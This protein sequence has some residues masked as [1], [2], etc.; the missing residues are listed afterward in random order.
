MII[1]RLIGG[2]GNQMFQY[3]LGRQL[4]VKNN[5]T[6]KLD[7]QA[8]KDYKLRNYDLDCF[9]ILENIAT[10]D[11]L[12][13]VIPPSDR[14]INKIGKHMN[15]RLK[16]IQ[17]I[18]YIKEQAF[19]FQQE[20]L[21]LKDNVYLDG[22]WQSEK[23]FFD[24]KNIILKDFT[25]KNSPDPVNESIMKEITECESV[26][27]H[28][29]RG[30]YVSNPITNQY[31][32]FL[33]LEYYQK[34]IRLILEKVGSPHFFVFS[35][36]PE[37]ASENIET[38]FPITYIKHNGDK[39]YEDL[40]LMSTCKHHIIANSSFS[41]WGS[42]LSRNEDKIVIAPKKWFNAALDTKDISLDSWHK[43]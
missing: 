42:W 38:D 16:G 24:I 34:A 23:Y 8:F 19:S 17:R 22:Y 18:Q 33:G 40:R 6:L 9:N 7:I 5:T 4:A 28:I 39:N 20:I 3:A 1:V 27:I 32:G 15:V 11:D 35:D 36:D 25:V 41:W 43:I 30:D 37:W 12:S 26:N 14:L 21:D 10:P 13:G 31:H 29:R 2:L